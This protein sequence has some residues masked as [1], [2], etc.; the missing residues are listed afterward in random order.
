MEEEATTRADA[1]TAMKNKTT[2]E[3]IVAHMKAL[4]KPE[5][6]V[7]TK[8]EIDGMIEQMTEPQT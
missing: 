8:T 4:H 1:I 6:P 3:K 7:P 2:E 5:E